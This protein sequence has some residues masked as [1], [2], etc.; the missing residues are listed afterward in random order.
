MSAALPSPPATSPGG[1]PLPVEA[2][3]DLLGGLLRERE[4][5]RQTGSAAALEENRRK[6]VDA[7]Q[8]LAAA[9][10]AKFAPASL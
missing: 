10:I 5:L 6:I 8:A 7:Q 9:L 4:S 3:Q 1:H 2:L